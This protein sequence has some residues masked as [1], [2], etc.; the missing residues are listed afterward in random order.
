VR[1]PREWVGPPEELVP[2]G[3][4]ADKPQSPPDA[5]RQPDFWGEDSAALQDAVESADVPALPPRPDMK[6]RLKAVG[7]V[8]LAA[9]LVVAAVLGVQ[10][11]G[12]SHAG[13]V[14]FAVVSIPPLAPTVARA[15]TSVSHRNPSHPSVVKWHRQT[16]RARSAGVAPSSTNPIATSSAA[17]PQSSYHPAPASSR[18]NGSS[19]SRSG[20]AFTLGGP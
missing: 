19:S 3:P 6:L 4:G 18:S 15:S 13:K 17:A 9:L 5:G 11:S 20:G 7:A 1:L 2:F 14:S 16:T 8:A 12:G 10:S